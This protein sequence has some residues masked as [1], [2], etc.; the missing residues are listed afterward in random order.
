MQQSILFI[1]GCFD[2]RSVISQICGY[3]GI[4]CLTIPVHEADTKRD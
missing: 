1:S 2:A 4:D 3:L